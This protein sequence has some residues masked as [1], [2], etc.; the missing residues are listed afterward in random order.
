[1]TKKQLTNFQKLVKDNHQILLDAGYSQSTIYSWR[2]GVYPHL[3][4]VAGLAK[5]LGV[6]ER[7]LPYFLP[8]RKD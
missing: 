7:E 5:V 2:N 3:H 6:D 8:I 4:K 1:M